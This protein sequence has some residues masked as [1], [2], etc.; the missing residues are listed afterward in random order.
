MFMLY[1]FTLGRSTL[2]TTNEALGTSHG[3][4]SFSCSS[5]LNYHVEVTLH[6]RFLI[7]NNEDDRLQNY[8]SIRT[9][10]M[11]NVFEGIVNLVR[12]NADEGSSQSGQRNFTALHC[13]ALLYWHMDWNMI[14]VWVG[15]FQLSLSILRSWCS[16]GTAYLD[17]LVT[18]GL[19]PC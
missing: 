15:G 18:P 1:Y 4:V 12:Y 3:W 6:L 8:V 7:D 14:L 17:H 5:Q 19:V 13:T 11:L 9:G 16:I 2:L 10:T